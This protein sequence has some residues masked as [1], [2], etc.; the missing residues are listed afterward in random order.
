ME[1]YVTPPARSHQP[2]PAPSPVSDR[3]PW[4]CRAKIDLLEI[5]KYNEFIQ[6][7]GIETIIPNYEVVTAFESALE[8]GEWKE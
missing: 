4:L 5:T 8:T 1:S 6:W 7:I 3:P 2:H